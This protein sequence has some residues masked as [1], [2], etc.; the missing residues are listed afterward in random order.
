MVKRH[1]LVSQS[2][3]LIFIYRSIDFIIKKKETKIKSKTKKN[4]REKDAILPF[5]AAWRGAARRFFRP[6]RRSLFSLLPF[7][8]LVLSFGPSRPLAP[9]LDRSLDIGQLFRYFSFY[10][11]TR[12]R[13]AP[14]RFLIGDRDSRT[15]S[16]RIAVAVAGYALASRQGH[17][18]RLRVRL[19]VRSSLFRFSIRSCPF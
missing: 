7:F 2:R 3:L 5:G 4:R 17:G 10:S 14:L 9:P 18:H 8:S 6:I 16:G 1:P 11:Y 12:S 13:S 19:L 15:S